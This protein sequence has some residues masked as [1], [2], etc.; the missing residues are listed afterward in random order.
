MFEYKNSYPIADIDDF[1]FGCLE[2]GEKIRS[3]ER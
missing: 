2:E 1:I 3:S